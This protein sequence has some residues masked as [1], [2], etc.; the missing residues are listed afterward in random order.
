MAPLLALLSSLRSPPAGLGAA[1]TPR[2][3][4][5]SGRQSDRAEAQSESGVADGASPIVTQPST[6]I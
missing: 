1:P 2:A 3:S 4:P 6:S 5:W